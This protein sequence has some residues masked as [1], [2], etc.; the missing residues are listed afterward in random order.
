[1]GTKIDHADRHKLTD[2]NFNTYSTDNGSK[3]S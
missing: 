1:M 2:D 3:K